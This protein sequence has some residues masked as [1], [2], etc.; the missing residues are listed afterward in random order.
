MWV[1]CHGFAET[2]VRR[3]TWV[4]VVV[5]FGLDYLDCI[6]RCLVYKKV[7]LM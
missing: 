4:F 6:L 1:Y 5:F 2:L 3:C 7:W